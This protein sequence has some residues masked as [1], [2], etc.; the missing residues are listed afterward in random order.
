MAKKTVIAKPQMN[1]TSLN[2]KNSIAQSKV[3][4]SNPNI[5]KAIEDFTG[6]HNA[7][8]IKPVPLGGEGTNVFTDLEKLKGS[9]KL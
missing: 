7:N 5:E 8:D 1:A 2:E 9:E 4:T 3:S 6:I